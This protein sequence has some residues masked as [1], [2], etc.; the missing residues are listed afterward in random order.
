MTEGG[1]EAAARFIQLADRRVLAREDHAARLEA[2]G[3]DTLEA[4]LDVQG[5]VFKSNRRR[6]VVRISLPGGERLFV[7]S[8]HAPPRP[9]WWRRVLGLPCPPP[10]AHEWSHLVALE[11]LGIGTMTP[12]ALA[13]E[14]GRGVGRRSALVTAAIEDAERVEDYLPRRFGGRDPPAEVRARK[15]RLIADLAGMARRFHEAGFFHKDFYLG[16][17]LVREAGA[18][19]DLYLIDLQRAERRERPRSRWYVKDLAQMLYTTPRP[20]VS[21]ADVLRFY[22]LYRGVERLGPAD[23]RL[24]AR[25]LAKHRRLVRRVERKGPIRDW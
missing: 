11:R 10:A 14:P 3:L 12:V 6:R 25:V 23:R 7:K 15:R 9:A 16:H 22:R 2:A 1:G 21:R 13:E 18:G 5:E 24:A 19:F 20:P 4:L 17:F 8:H